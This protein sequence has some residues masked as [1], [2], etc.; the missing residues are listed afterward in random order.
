[1]IT[2][3]H[4]VT[5]ARRLSDVFAFVAGI[6]NLPQWQSEVV[7]S[8]VTTPGPT[9][10]GTRF[11]EEVK[12]VGKKVPT[13]CEVTDFVPDQ[14]IGFT[15]TSP[16][17]DYHGLFTVSDNNNQATDVTLKASVKLKSWFRLA[18]PLFARE[19]R[20]GARKELATLKQLAE[21]A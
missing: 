21:A 12:I 9:R 14:R 5:I 15:A 20:N 11:S 13:A 17:I 19:V 18:A 16:A 1:M 7:T 3:D 10:V 4:T 8:T 2:I 6:E